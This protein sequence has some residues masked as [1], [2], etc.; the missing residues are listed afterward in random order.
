VRAGPAVRPLRRDP[1]LRERAWRPARATRRA[2]G[3]ARGRPATGGLSRRVHRTVE[4]GAPAARAHRGPG[5]D[6]RLLADGVVDPAAA[7]PRGYAG[8]LRRADGAFEDARQRA[9]RADG[10]RHAAVG[11]LQRG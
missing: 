4:A 6:V 11:D 9:V 10:V 1:G 2:D 5:A 8:P 7:D 3:P